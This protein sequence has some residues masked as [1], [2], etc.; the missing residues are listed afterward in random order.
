M[1]ILRD[2]NSLIHFLSTDATK[3]GLMV[4]S[5]GFIKVDDLL[6]LD[7]FRHL[8]SSNILS[9]GIL[10]NINYNIRFKLRNNHLIIGLAEGHTFPVLTSKLMTTITLPIAINVQSAV[11]GCMLSELNYYLKWGIS[12]RANEQHILLG[13]QLSQHLNE[14]EAF[15]IID[16]NRVL[17]NGIILYLTPS[18]YILTQGNHSGIIPVE[19]FKTAVDWNLNKLV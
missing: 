15:I 2:I 9:I 7:M 16:I 12:R 5:I 11:F 1:D 14:Y 10:N 17:A 13:S 18:Q 8:N 3:S 4:D 6:T 19:C